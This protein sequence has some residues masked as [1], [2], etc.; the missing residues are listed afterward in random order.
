MLSFTNQEFWR[1][2]EDDA[3]ERCEALDLI[4]RQ[5]PTDCQLVD[6]TKSTF[7]AGV[8]CGMEAHVYGG[9]FKRF[10][11]T[12]FIEAVV[13]APWRDPD[14]VQWFLKAES[15]ECFTLSFPCR[16]KR[17]RARKSSST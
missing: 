10:D 5:L 15:A 4:N 13:A 1:D 3:R 2:G 12:G 7:K 9:G 17:K 8:G 6:L 11:S 14:N 16:A